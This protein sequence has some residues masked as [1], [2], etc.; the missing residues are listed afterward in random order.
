MTNTT[1]PIPEGLWRLRIFPAE[2]LS[3]KRSVDAWVERDGARAVR[4]QNSDNNMTL[5]IPGT[6]RTAICVAACHVSEPL[7]KSESSSAG[8][9]RDNR[10]KPDLIAPGVSITTAMA[11]TTKDGVESYGTSMAAPMVTGVLA[12]ALSHLHK[13]GPDHQ[14]NAV[15]LRKHLVRTLANRGSHHPLFG[16]GR[17]DA[18]AFF[19]AI[20]PVSMV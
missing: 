12:L 6:A 10:P 13:K 8:L 3:E 2:I 18:K 9:T 15:E 17:L 7:K 19:K 5:T 20:S 1:N 16:H 4:F 14:M 11:G